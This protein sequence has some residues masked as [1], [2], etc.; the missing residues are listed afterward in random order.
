[1]TDFITSEWLMD[2]TGSSCDGGMVVAKQDIAAAEQQQTAGEL[3]LDQLQEGGVT[4]SE[5]PEYVAVRAQ[6][7][8][9]KKLLVKARAR[10]NFAL[11]K[12]TEVERREYETL[13][14]EARAETHGQMAEDPLF[15]K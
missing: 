5:A 7:E 9:A 4:P 1:M 3:K 10:L 8:D 14:A 12:M 15:N 11:D 13:H 6:I 2:K